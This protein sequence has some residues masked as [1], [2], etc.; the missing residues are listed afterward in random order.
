MVSPKAL[1]MDTQMQLNWRM[2]SFWHVGALLCAFLFFFQ[3]P[4][5]A[6]SSDNVELLLQGQF[7]SEEA[8]ASSE[9]SWEP[10]GILVTWKNL[11]PVDT[12]LGFLP[13]EFD[14]KLAVTDSEG[15]LVARTMYGKR[16]AECQGDDASSTLPIGIKTL[17]PGEQVTCEVS[18]MRQFDL[19]LPGTYY[20]RASRYV[21]PLGEKELGV[22]ESNSLKIIVD[23]D[24]IRVEEQL[25]E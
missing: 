10:K 18:L 16:I 4:R 21:A 15:E 23:E 22:I 19:S 9:D 5:V 13:P 17:K 14:L 6:R 2:G 12:T 11:R 1:K 7:D 20:V 25:D 3:L 8:V 24:G